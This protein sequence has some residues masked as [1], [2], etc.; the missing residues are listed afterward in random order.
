MPKL[1]DLT[2]QKFGKL[3]VMK[4]VENNKYRQSRWLCRCECGKE[5]VTSQGTLKY[6]R[7]KSCGCLR[8]ETSKTNGKDNYGKNIKNL[9]GM[10]FG[11]LTVIKEGNRKNYNEQSMITWECKCDCGSYREVTSNH[12][13]SGQTKS[14]GCL[15]KE[16]ARVN[17]IRAVETQL[18]KGTKPCLLTSKLFNNNS[19]GYKGV[20]FRKT[21]GKWRARITFK[22]KGIYLGTYEKLEDAIQARKEAEEKYFKPIIEEFEI[23]K[24][25]SYDQE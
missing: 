2:G 20:E 7:T 15:V 18:Y 6:G 23:L 13:I 14:C 4:R 9:I 12:L 17:Q 8:S 10:R 25:T 1:K 24:E 3:T 19:S 11:L 16:T 5:C 22:G 21:S